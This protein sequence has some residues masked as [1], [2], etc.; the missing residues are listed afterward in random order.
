[1]NIS[2]F[3]MHVRKEVWEFKKLLFW[4]PIILLSLLVAMPLIQLLFIESYQW[5]NILDV[6]GRIQEQTQSTQHSKIGQIAFASISGLFVPFMLVA[7]LVQLY[8]FLACLFDE[9]RD[10]SI[11]FWRSMPVS[12]AM[13]IGVKFLTGAFVIP[14]IFMLAATATLILTLVLAVIACFTLMIGYDISLWHLWGSIDVLSNIAIVWASILPFV[15]WLFPL[16]SWLMLASMFANKAP[17][18]WALLP[19]VIIILVEA[20]VV[21][22][23][24]LHSTFFSSM[25]LNYFGINEHSVQ[26]VYVVSGNM[27][28]MP[29]KVLMSKISVY[30]IAVG[31]ILIYIT[32]WLRANRSHL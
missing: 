20:F 32:Y 15:L 5:N 29:L 6:L 25:L 17:F 13:T 12:D 31:G 18:L 2:T 4:V 9:R 3:T 14:G 24:N 28:F 7:L 1:M 21:H 27:K 10:L 22:Y 26:Q 11:Y 8:Y 19:V 30:G 23:F 16:F